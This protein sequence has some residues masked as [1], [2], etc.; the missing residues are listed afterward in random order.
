VEAQ[1]WQRAL[2]NKDAALADKDA[3]NARLREQLAAM[4]AK[5]ESASK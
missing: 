3:E 2:A 5:I 1:K 4:Q